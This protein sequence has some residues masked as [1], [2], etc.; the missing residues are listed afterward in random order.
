MLTYKTTVPTVYYHEES[1]PEVGCY[2][3]DINIVFNEDGTITFGERRF[4]PKDF[5]RILDKQSQFMEATKLMNKKIE[6]DK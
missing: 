4:M 1:Y 3:E 6:N 2:S 5:E